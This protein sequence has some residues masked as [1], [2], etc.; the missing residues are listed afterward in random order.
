MTCS[1]AHAYAT[2]QAE[3]E[4][5][6]H[7][8]RGIYR[9]YF[10]VFIITMVLSLICMLGD[11]QTIRGDWGNDW[12]AIEVKFWTILWPGA[13]FCGCMGYVLRRIEQSNRMDTLIR[14]IEPTGIF[15]TLYFGTFFCITKDRLMKL[16]GSTFEDLVAQ[17]EPWQLT[18]EWACNAYVHHTVSE[19]PDILPCAVRMYEVDSVICLVLVAFFA[20][21]P[22]RLSLQ[23]VLSMVTI[24]LAE[25]CAFRHIL[26]DMDSSEWHLQISALLLG[27]SRIAIA[28]L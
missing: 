19:V 9:S 20:V 18:S 28:Q 16:A 11:A 3:H 8:V 2:L 25:Y 10:L 5:R 1:R 14:M 13:L 27:V 17:L 15:A 7:R 6:E 23:S 12:K 26:G 24:I 4:Y 21:G 22:A